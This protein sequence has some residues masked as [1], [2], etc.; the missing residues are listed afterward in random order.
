MKFKV[1]VAVF[2]LTAAAALMVACSNSSIAPSRVTTSPVAS[3]VP[4]GPGSEAHSE[5]EG[6]EELGV[7]QTNQGSSEALIAS[8][9]AIAAYSTV[10]AQTVAA[11]TF[12]PQPTNPPSSALPVVSIRTTT[13]NATIRYTADGTEPGA[14]SIKYSTAV[15]LIK[16]TTLK[17][18]AFK[19]GMTT[20][21]V[22][23]K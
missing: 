14:S 19:D 23:K 2:V 17:A 22:L 10:S 15:T 4:T 6:T 20:S 12:N 5:D 9:R 11:P 1:V 18:R 3:S 21:R 7:N 16:T 13:A 8:S